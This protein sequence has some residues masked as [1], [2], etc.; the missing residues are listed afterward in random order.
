[1]R[2]SRRLQYAAKFLGAHQGMTALHEAHA[3][4]KRLQEPTMNV[5]KKMMQWDADDPLLQPK[6]S[7]PDPDAS[8]FATKTK[9]SPKKDPGPPNPV[10]Q[11][12][13]K[14]SPATQSAKPRVK[15]KTLTPARR[16]AQK[17]Q[18]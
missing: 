12:T 3:K 8:S 13:P 6:R 1:M 15:P 5:T 7:K 2:L 9:R 14:P 11:R 18:K 4:A 10:T 17:L 16:G